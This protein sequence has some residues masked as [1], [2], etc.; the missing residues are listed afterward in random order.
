VLPYRIAFVDEDGEG[1][2]VIDIILDSIFAIDVIV[3]FFPAY[4]DH[5][6]NIIKNRKVHNIY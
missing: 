3:N 6:D 4:M 1:R 2:I 5:E